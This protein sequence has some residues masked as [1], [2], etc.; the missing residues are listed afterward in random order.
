M[1]ETQVEEM[2]RRAREEGY[3]SG[4]AKGLEEGRLEQIARTQAK[5][6]ERLNV[7]EKQV[8]PGIYKRLTDVEK[9]LI[10]FAGAYL[11]IQFAPALRGFLQ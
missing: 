1:S 11:M 8:H 7:H 4:M 3:Q 2:M 6:E 10:L 5:H 9:M